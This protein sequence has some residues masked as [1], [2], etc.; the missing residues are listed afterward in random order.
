MVLTTI[1]Q[2][3]I[4]SHSPIPRIQRIKNLAHNVHRNYLPILRPSKVQ[5]IYI[6]ASFVVQRDTKTNA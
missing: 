1:N 3:P 5:Q 6:Q 2:N 4:T